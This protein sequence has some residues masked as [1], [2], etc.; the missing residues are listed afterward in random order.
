MENVIIIGSGPAG[1]TAGIYTARA[2]LSPL[3]IEGMNALG[4]LIQTPEVE[5]FPGFAE[6]VSGIDLMTS[7]RK[8]AEKAGVRFAMDEISSVN[9][10]G[11]ELKLSGMAGDYS[12]KTVIIATGAE[13][14]WTGIEGEST[15]R[16]RGISA[17][18]TCDGAFHK[19]RS[20]A[21]IGGG[22]TALSDALYLSRICEKVT[23]IHRR[24]EFRGT[25]VLADQVLA[26]PNIDVKWNTTVTSFEGDGKRLNAISLSDNDRLDVSGVFVAIGH[27]PKTAFLKGAV[28]LDENGYIKVKNTHTSH[29]GVFAAGDCADPDYKQAV[30]AAGTGAE[31]AL[32]VQRYL[33]SVK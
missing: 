5:N 30:S 1:L 2:G 14:K 10:S 3:V 6:P 29:P 33:E 13:A 24:G 7:M 18:A 21:V 32:E 19:G 27:A 23:V 22:D 25:K 8:Q 15:Y 26:T 4:Q 16:N 28:E 31:A 12:S 9:F 11:S 17:C 20:V